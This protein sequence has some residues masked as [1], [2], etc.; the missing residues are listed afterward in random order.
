MENLVNK[1]FNKITKQNNILIMGSK[2]VELGKTKKLCSKSSKILISREFDQQLER[3]IKLFT[4]QINNKKD[5][6]IRF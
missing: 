1:A 6:N 2:I 5:L 3:E 4:S